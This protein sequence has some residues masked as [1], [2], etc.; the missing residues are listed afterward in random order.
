[1]KFSSNEGPTFFS[2][3]EYSEILKINTLSKILKSAGL[4]S[5]KLDT[6]NPWMKGIQVCSNEEPLNAHIV[7]NVSSINQRYDVTFPDE[8]CGPSCLE[9]PK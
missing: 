2:R 8:R 7:N 5:T 1:M 9:K 4:I 3:V 6:M